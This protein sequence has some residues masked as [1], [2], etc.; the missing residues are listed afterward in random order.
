MPEIRPCYQFN[1][2]I[3][4]TPSTSIVN[5][6]RAQDRG[7]PDFDGVM[8]E[9][10]GYIKALES[11]GADVT[12]LPCLDNFP[13]AVF[14]EDPA[15]V[16]SEGAVLLRPGAPSRQGETEEIAPV[17]H[18]MFDRVLDLPY[19]GFADGGDVLVTPGTVMIGLSARTDETGAKG[20]IRQLGRLGYKGEIVNTPREI[21][22]FKTGC[23]LL[24]DETI[25]VTKQMDTSGI[26]AGFN[27]MILPDGEEPAANA[28][29]FRDM[30]LVSAKYK[31]AIDMLDKAGYAV[32][33]VKTDEIEKVDAGLSCMSLRWFN[34]TL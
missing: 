23:S 19:P 5:G 33:P 31:R 3:V 32:C 29:R 34:P 14:V 2:A 11:A 20:L 30:V 13:D 7:N 9:H 18:D 8:S 22:H 15:L 24:D 4:R 17:L 26:F 28:V 10:R 21:L 6:L 1:S 25:L 12:V 16:F 27:T